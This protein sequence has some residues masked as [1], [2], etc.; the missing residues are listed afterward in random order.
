MSPARRTA[1]ATACALAVTALLA[2]PAEAKVKTTVAN[3]ILQLQGGDGSERARVRCDDAG[4]VKVNGRN[5][6]GGA[7][8]CERIVEVDAAMGG[9]D[10]TIDFS[11][12]TGAFGEARFPGFGVATGTAAIGGAGNDRYIPS[13]AAFNIFYGQAGNDRATGGPAR[14]VLDGGPGDDRLN[15]AGG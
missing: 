6:K 9:G 12:I 15:G 1:T 10:D 8:P 3:R 13:R 5:P 4:D 2:A 14:D 11:G 7:V